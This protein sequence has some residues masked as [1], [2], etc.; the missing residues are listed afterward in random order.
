MEYSL[1]INQRLENTYEQAMVISKQLKCAATAMKH[2]Q[3]F[4]NIWLR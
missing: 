4:E 1:K 3:S 2:V